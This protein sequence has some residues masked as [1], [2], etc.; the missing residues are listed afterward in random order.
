VQLLRIRYYQVRRDLKI[1]FFII[2]AL[3]FYLCFN[4][5]EGNEK[6]ANGIA[7]ISVLGLY[8]YHS[9]R[10]DLKFAYY[11]LPTGQ[12]QVLLNY[13]LTLLPVSLAL[14]IQGHILSA[15]AAHA[16]A[17]LFPSIPLR[18][19]ANTFKKL[20]SKI[21]PSHFEYIAGVRS[22][23]YIIVPL[24]LLCVLLSPVKLF[25]LIP[26]FLLNVIILGFHNQ[27]EP[28]I[29]LNPGDLSASA[30]LNLKIKYLGT[31]LILL[32]FPLLLINSIFNQDVIV[33]NIYFLLIFYFVSA[34][35]IYIKYAQYEPGGKLSFSVDSLIVLATIFIPYL[36]P[37]TLLVFINN[38]K[39]AKSNLELYLND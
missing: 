6:Y 28:R 18:S 37:L 32:N 13:Q 17:A 15:L 33:I 8:S 22:G 5:S 7:A 26:I 31:I 12:L 9:S 35:S 3:V 20:T 19:V 14:L 23:F 27:F 16:L 2:I 11:Q 36:L 29:L 24:L 38:R 1:W 4:I 39:K 21:E 25:A 34:C 10:K 30:F